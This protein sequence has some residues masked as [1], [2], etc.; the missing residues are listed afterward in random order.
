MQLSSHSKN[1][2]YVLV[3]LV[4]VFPVAYSIG[5][6]NARLG[7][8]SANIEAEK[9]DAMCIALVKP[10]RMSQNIKAALSENPKLQEWF[11]AQTKLGRHLK[12]Y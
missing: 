2:I 7:A 4:V 11:S 9:P 1:A 10:P 8:I 12:C 3:A 5:D 6:K